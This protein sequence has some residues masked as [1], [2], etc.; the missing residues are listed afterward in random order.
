MESREFNFKSLVDLILSQ[1]KTFLIVLIIGAVVG[2]VISMPSIMVP[3]F[4][5]VA[6]VYPVNLVEYSDESETEQLLQIFE[7]SSVR[8]SIIAKFDLYGRYGIDPNAAQSRFYLLEEYSDRFTASKTRYESV[9]LEVYD[10]DPV[11][12]QAMADEVLRQVN[13]KFNFLANQRGRNLARSYKRQMDYQAT[14]IDSVEALVSRISLEKGILDY[15]AQSR[16][17]LRGYI[18]ASKSGN[19]SQRDQIQEWLRG[20][21]ESGSTVKMLQNVSEWAVEQRSEVE[22][23]YLFWREFAFRDINYIDVIVSPEVADKKA[24]P[25][26]WLVVAVSMLSAMLLALVLVALGKSKAHQ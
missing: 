4:K 10:E 25:V 2:V 8:D 22:A 15:E 1:W 6:V 3:R 18:G 17:L 5:S 12:A 7:S 13:Q 20:A 26:R 16:E 9:R 11:V 21:Q 19:S 14:V 24:W 23:K